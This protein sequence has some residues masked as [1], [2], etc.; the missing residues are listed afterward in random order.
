MFASVP[1]VLLY[2]KSS[3]DL[4]VFTDTPRLY[5]FEPS[6]GMRTTEFVCTDG[7]VYPAPSLSPQLSGWRGESGGFV[8]FFMFAG[9]KPSL[10]YAPPS[11]L[12]VLM[13]TASAGSPGPFGTF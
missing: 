9:I 2:V 4:P 5:V 7:G 1:L 8:G 13:G 10:F 6:L 3:H 11:W 12:Y